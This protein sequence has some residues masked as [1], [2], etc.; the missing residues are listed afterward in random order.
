M[1][2]SYLILHHSSPELPS[3][4]LACFLPTTHKTLSC[5][6]S[7]WLVPLPQ[8]LSNFFDLTIARKTLSIVT[9]E[10]MHAYICMYVHTY[11][12]MYEYIYN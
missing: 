1:Y 8:W 2:I 11:T 4:M 12:H 10:G 7:N 6:Y 3:A 9:R 5:P